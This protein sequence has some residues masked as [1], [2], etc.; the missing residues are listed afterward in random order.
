MTCARPGAGRGSRRRP[1]PPARTASR[2]RRSRRRRRDRRGSPG[3]CGPRAGWPRRSTRAGGA[4][5]PSRRPS[6]RAAD[7]TRTRPATPRPRSSDRTGR[8]AAPR[9]RGSPSLPSSDRS[10]RPADPARRPPAPWQIPAHRTKT[11]VTGRRH[12][13]L[14]VGA[15]V[16]RDAAELVAEVGPLFAPRRHVEAE[17]VGEE[18]ERRRPADPRRAPRAWSRRTPRSVRGRPAARPMCR[19][20]RPAVGV[21][22]ALDPR[23][24]RRRLRPRCPRRRCVVRLLMSIA[25]RN[26]LADP[27]HDLVPDRPEQPAE[28]IRPRSSRSLGCPISTTSSPT[29]TSSSPQS[30]IS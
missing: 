10:A 12:I 4:G 8:D 15:V 3:G 26:A 1:A 18:E 20:G 29:C 17:P 23:S 22:T 7:R 30:T 13:A 2:G 19:R 27:A 25:S 28:R 5:V 21:A 11:H 6:R 9:A 24:P 16:E 14:A